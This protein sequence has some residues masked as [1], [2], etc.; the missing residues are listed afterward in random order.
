M[1]QNMTDITMLVAEHKPH[2]FGITEA[3]IKSNHDQA[4]L[5][6]PGYSLHLPSSLNNPSLGNIARVAVYVHKT[7]TVKRRL[8]LEDEGLQMICL[9]A[10]LPGKKK[11]IYIVGY[12]QWQLSGQT[13]K[14]SSSVRSQSERWDRLLTRW[15]AALQEGKE[16]ITVLDA[17]LDAMT[18]RKDRNEIPRHSSSLT[19]TSLIDA[20]Y[21]RI[22]PMGVELMTPAKP[23]W[24]RG[25]Q[26]S[27]LDHVYTTSPGRLS[28]VSVIWTGMSDHALVK[29]ARFCKTIESRQ[30][31]VKKRTFKNFDNNEFKQRVAE[32]QELIYIQLC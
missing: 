26:R 13:D 31:Y 20:L 4:D 1:Y 24:A 27:C 8:D 21:N 32:M 14:T 17:N 18:W 22:L 3:D 23:T 5:I 6:I 29:F 9:E 19:H 2:I 11:S 10:G 15:E 12:R 7:I 25:N 16:V 28:P 30:S